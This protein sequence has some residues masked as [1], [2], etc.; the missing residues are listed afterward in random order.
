MFHA[1]L[2]FLFAF[3]TPAFAEVKIATVD[4]QRALNEVGEGA[5]ARSKL[6]SMFSDKKAAVDK[7]RQ[8]V[9]K[10]Q[11]DLEKQSVILSDAAKKEKEDELQKA[12]LEYQQAAQRSE[13][14]MQQAYYGAMETLIDKMKKI[15][16][17]IGTERGYT[18][19]VEINEGGIV[20][21]S[22]TVDITEELIK[23]YNA[24][25]PSS[26]PPSPAPAPKK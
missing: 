26:S 7:M 22:P 10:M 8:N 17:T 11:A 2:A 13:G 19:V 12:Y 24:Q 15:A 14:E 21:A 16:Q 9:E 6:E 18:L 25:N 4:F 3:V 1:L 20:Y 23:R 5:A